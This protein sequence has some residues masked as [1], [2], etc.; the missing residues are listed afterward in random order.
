MQC[1]DNLLFS[2]I[3]FWSVSYETQANQ[4]TWGVERLGP[5][6]VLESLSGVEHAQLSLSE[7]F[8]GHWTYWFAW[9]RS[10]EAWHVR[11]AKLEG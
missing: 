2:F 10:G 1:K 8:G 4:G 9:Y 11:E 7:S 3:T 6:F 5:S